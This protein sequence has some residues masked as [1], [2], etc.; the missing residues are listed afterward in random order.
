MSNRSSP[1]PRF[2][3]AI[4]NICNVR[5]VWKKTVAQMMKKYGDRVIWVVLCSS[6]TL[7]HVALKIATSTRYHIKVK[8]SEVMIY[9]KYQ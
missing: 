7:K 1:K 9:L 6:K 5:L 3:I 8:L 2:Q 4:Y